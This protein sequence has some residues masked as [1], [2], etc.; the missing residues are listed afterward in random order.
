MREGRILEL[1]DTLLPDWQWQRLLS[2]NLMEG[3]IGADVVQEILE[4]FRRYLNL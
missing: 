2:S 4:P 3:V 1:D